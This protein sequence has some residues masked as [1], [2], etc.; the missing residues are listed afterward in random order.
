VPIDDKESAMTTRTRIRAGQVIAFQDG[1]HCLLE[2]G[3]VVLH[4][5]RII[6]V[7]RAFAGEVD[8]E[9]DARRQLVTPGLINTHTHV[10]TPASRGLREDGGNPLFHMSGLYEYLPITWQMPPE[11]AAIC[12]EATLIEL[13]RNG[14]T[15]ALVLGT[16]IPEEVA[17]IAGRL[18]MRLYLSPGYKSAS[19]GIEDGA[20]VGYT[21]DEA[22]GL[23]GLERNI[24]L[25]RTLD[26]SHG[27]LVRLFLG[28][29]QVDTCSPELLQRSAG[30]ARELGALVQ[31]HA[32]QSLVEFQEIRRR[33][34]LTPI[35]LLDSVGLLGPHVS[36]AHCIFVAGHS[37]TATPAE[38]DL[39]LLAD[40]GTH[41]AHCPGVFARSGVAL[42]SLARYLRAGVRMALGTDSFPQDLL[43]E[44]RLAALL[45]KLV[46]RDARVTTAGELFDLATL[47]GADLLDRPDLGRIAPGCQAD[48]LYF[49]LDRVNLSPARDPLRN[50]VYSATGPDVARVMVGGRTVVD[51]GRVLGTD[52]P[53]VAAAFD[54]AAQ[55]LWATLPGV[56]WARRDLEQL[57]PLSLPH[58]DDER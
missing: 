42:E 16:S 52:E 8:R 1:R 2:D 40:S 36:L 48:L 39:Q 15:T 18:G 25:F 28:P 31:I 13:L 46:E 19:W 20:R 51:R 55:R 9:I 22:G 6:H 32:G 47:G 11:D 38:N 34:G 43:Q 14:S 30:A 21:H 58:W 33:S 3:E 56:D 7:G 53:V 49:S 17:A 23:A 27:D 45:A 50:L 4:G 26:R 44:M 37:W 57:A 12:A 5:D 41:V 10:T 29:L 24:D 54:K 35:Q